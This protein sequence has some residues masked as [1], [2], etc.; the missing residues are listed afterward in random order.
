MT[1]TNKNFKIIAA[2][3]RRRRRMLGM[4][5]SG[6][7]G[8]VRAGNHI[9]LGYANFEGPEYDFN[10]VQ[11]SGDDQTA[12]EYPSSTYQFHWAR[13]QVHDFDT[14]TIDR[15]SGYG[16]N[17]P[18][19]L[20][21]IANT[22]GPAY[23]LPAP[24]V[25]PDPVT[26]GNKSS[27]G[28]EN[29]VEFSFGIPTGKVWEFSFSMRANTTTDAAITVSLPCGNNTYYPLGSYFTRDTG[30]L[31]HQT[32]SQ[33]DTWER[34]TIEI[35]LTKT[36]PSADR[37]DLSNDPED[38]YEWTKGTYSTAGGQEHP[39]GHWNNSLLDRIAYTSDFSTRYISNTTYISDGWK[40]VT[41][42]HTL[43]DPSH[44]DYTTYPQLAHPSSNNATYSLL[45]PGD[46]SRVGIVF[47]VNAS[48]THSIEYHIDD[49]SFI[50][51]A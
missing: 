21:M 14:V 17:G 9:P 11:T 29:N 18:H 51:K 3:S 38:S 23:V 6:G 22:R 27:N 49:L 28:E 4:M 36:F 44:A 46:A 24:N 31:V 10:F 20:R 26:F 45:N 35:D 19:T 25:V 42:S 32:V 47:Y 50:E 16:T 12:G 34:K 48:A 1:I 30:S 43:G 39:W 37:L 13:S 5:D 8:F 33:A 7:E 2:A 41:T 40:K 15:D